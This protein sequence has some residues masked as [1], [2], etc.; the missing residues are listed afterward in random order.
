LPEGLKPAF[1][2]VA[3][4]AAEEKKCLLGLAMNLWG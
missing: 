2:S 3:K 1:C 4:R